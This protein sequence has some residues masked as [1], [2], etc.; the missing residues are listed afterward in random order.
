[1]KMIWAYSTYFPLCYTTIDIK[2][3][4]LVD[5]FMQLLFAMIKGLLEKGK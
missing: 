2:I 1:M 5:I 3:D 4:R